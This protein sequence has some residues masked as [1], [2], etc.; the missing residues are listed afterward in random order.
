MHEEHDKKSEQTDAGLGRVIYNVDDV[1]PEESPG[2]KKSARREVEIADRESFPA[3][4]SPSFSGATTG[5]PE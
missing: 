1:A 3:S 4:D 2:E 5:D